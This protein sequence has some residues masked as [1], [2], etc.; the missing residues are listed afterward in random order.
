VAYGDIPGD[1]QAQAG[2]AATVSGRSSLTS[3]SGAAQAT[4][5]PHR[6]RTRRS[7]LNARSGTAKQISWKSKPAAC[8]MLQDSP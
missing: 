6:R 4:A 1:R 3:S 2:A 7:R 5:T 8:W